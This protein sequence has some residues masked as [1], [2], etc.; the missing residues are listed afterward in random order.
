M[1]GGLIYKDKA[2]SFS[3]PRRRRRRP[4]ER[5]RG[6]RSYVP[7]ALLHD[8]VQ[9]G[10]HVFKDEIELVVLADDLLELDDVGMRRQS[11]QGLNFPQVVDLDAR[12]AKPWKVRAQR[13]ACQT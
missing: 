6:H 4:F 7:L 2:G 13:R 12:A 9:V 11:T 10:L 5:K 3:L 8:L 1:L